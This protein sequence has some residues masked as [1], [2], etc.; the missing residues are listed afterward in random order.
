MTVDAIIL[1]SLWKALI[2]VAA[3]M[4]SGYILAWHDYRRGTNWM[5]NFVFKGRRKIDK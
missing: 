1:D 4:T 3:S 2:P 5:I